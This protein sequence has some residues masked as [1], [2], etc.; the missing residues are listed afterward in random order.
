MGWDL[1]LNATTL[2]QFRMIAQS[3]KATWRES[4]MSVR[5]YVR[6]DP[7]IW[8]SPLYQ[9]YLKT[10]NTSILV[11]ERLKERAEPGR[12]IYEFVDYRGNRFFRPY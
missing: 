2:M 8:I 11:E 7:R 1:R 6:Q 10:H 4:C 9:I 5:G 12:E 3:S